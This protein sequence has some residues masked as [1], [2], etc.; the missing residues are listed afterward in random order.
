MQGVWF[1]G[2]V[3][4]MALAL[5]L[6]GWVQNRRDGSVHA[7]FSGPAEDVDEML[8]LCGQGPPAA[9]VS[10]VE[11][12]PLNEPVQSGFHIRPTE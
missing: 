12:L 1:R 3:N 5:G 4:K 6:N 7:V 9:D 8:Q 11:R 10:L 2:W